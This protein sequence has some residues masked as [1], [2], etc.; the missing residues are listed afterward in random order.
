MNWNEL[1]QQIIQAA[2]SSFSD[3]MLT[4]KDDDFYAFILYTDDDCYTILPSANSIQKLNEKILKRGIGDPKRIAGYKWS[5][6][7]WAYEA[8]HDDEFSQICDALSEASEVASSDG[9]F[10]TFKENTHQSMIDALRALD[11]EGFFG[12]IRKNIAIFISSSD[13][14][15]S[16]AIENNSAKLLN[17]SDLYEKFVNRYDGAL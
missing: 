5:I 8:W 9:T 1:I 16:I 6:G 10:S 14:D 11:Q 13:Y 7:E 4:H 15:E 2:R 17:S 12:A 3:L